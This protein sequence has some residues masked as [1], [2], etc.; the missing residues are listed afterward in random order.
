MTGE[1]QKQKTDSVKIRQNRRTFS[2][3]NRRYR[4]ILCLCLIKKKAQKSL[5]EETKREKRA[6]HSI[7]QFY[8]FS[9]Y[10]DRR[11]YHLT[12]IFGCIWE[13]YI[14]FFCYYYF[15]VACGKKYKERNQ[16]GFSLIFCLFDLSPLSPLFGVSGVRWLP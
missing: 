3:L 2:L 1:Q 4:E 11:K 10:L 8:S 13:F 9:E 14:L 15:F 7:F 6:S 12:S 5:E 16:T